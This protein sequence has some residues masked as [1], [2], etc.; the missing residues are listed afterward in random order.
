MPPADVSVAVSRR[1]LACVLDPVLLLSHAASPRVALRLAQ[2]LEPWLTRS[3]WQTLDASE[4]LLDR[5][6]NDPQP[7]L[8]AAAITALCDLRASRDACSLP[9]RW[10]GDRLPESVLGDSAEPA[11]VE[12]YE[13]LAGALQARWQRQA[14]TAA[15]PAESV[16]WVAAGAESGGATDLEPVREWAA[17]TMVRRSRAAPRWTFDP[18]PAALD[19]AAVSAL[20]DGAPVLCAA[21]AEGSPPTPWA[22][23]ALQRVGV[24]PTLLQP[25]PADSIFAAERAHLRDALAAAGLAALVEA[26]PRLAV[27]HASVEADAPG[28]AGDDADPWTGARA[29]WYWL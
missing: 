17:A 1:K 13:W 19:A 20:F 28:D 16:V 6:A 22:V 10:I 14:G 29:W 27:L 15:R 21:A 26:M 18:E 11:D 4:L 7:L 3:L 9:F 25:L 12:Q 5:L 24:E 23:L 2:T 8:S